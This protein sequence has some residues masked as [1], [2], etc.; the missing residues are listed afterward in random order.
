M[1]WH[2]FFLRHVY[3]AATKSKDKRTKIG[4]VLVRDKNIIATGY[5]GFARGVLD[6]DERYDNRELKHDF[7]CHAEFNSIVTAARL[8]VCTDKSTLYSQGIPCAACAK[9]IIQGGVTKIVI[10]KQWPNLIHDKKW[11]DSI[12]LSNTMFEEANIIIE[13]FDKVLGV[14]GFLDG[15]EINV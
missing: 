5:N 1:N 15:K 14:V 7:I 13:N 10:H 8:G 12:E 9:A 4:A 3:L 6:S 2:E 11:I